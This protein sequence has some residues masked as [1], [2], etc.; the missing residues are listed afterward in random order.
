MQRERGDGGGTC[1]T[2]RTAA[3]VDWMFKVLSAAVRTCW[4]LALA[5]L[6]GGRRRAAVQPHSPICH[7]VKCFQ[8]GV[9]SQCG[10]PGTLATC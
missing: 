8:S 9:A 7:L 5:K 3:A 6:R 10:V 4:V 1:C 2:W